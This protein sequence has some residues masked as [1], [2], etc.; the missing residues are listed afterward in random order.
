M[1]NTMTNYTVKN[2]KTNAHFDFNTT[3]EKAI[4]FFKT[5]VTFVYDVTLDFDV[6]KKVQSLAD[7]GFVKYKD[8]YLEIKD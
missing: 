2:V 5:A 8:V 6:T 4:D 1:V 7:N 3:S